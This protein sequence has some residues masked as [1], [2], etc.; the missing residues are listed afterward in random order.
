MTE[1]MSG[2]EHAEDA[3]SVTVARALDGLDE[4]LVDQLVSRARAGG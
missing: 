1:M 3:E 2:V 4:Q